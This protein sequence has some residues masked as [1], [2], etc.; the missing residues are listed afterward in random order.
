MKPRTDDLVLLHLG[1]DI[2]DTLCPIGEREIRRRLDKAVCRLVGL[3][4]ESRQVFP[5]DR[6]VPGYL[7]GLLD[8]RF[9]TRVVGVVCRRRT[10]LSVDPNRDIRTSTDTAAARQE[11]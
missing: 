4:T 8:H 11:V 5:I 2:A 10:A 6:R 3:L 1:K 7:F 9:Q